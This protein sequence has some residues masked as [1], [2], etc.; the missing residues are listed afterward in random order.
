MSAVMERRSINPWTWQEPLGYEQAVETTGVERILWCAG[1]TAIGPDGRVVPGEM[2]G[3]IALSID[4]LEAVLSQ[5]GLML[6]NVVRITWYVTSIE[7][8][9]EAAPIHRRR[10][11]DAGCRAAST[12]IEVSSLAQPELL[13][14]ITATAVA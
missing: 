13:V 11:S 2:A 6:A 10:L 4:N 1:Q 8:Y 3:Q 7:Q 14:E 12:L 9:R 5:A